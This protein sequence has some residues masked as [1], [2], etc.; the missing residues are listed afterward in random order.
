METACA[1]A[2][3]LF[4]CLIGYG[5]GKTRGI[6]EGREEALFVGKA[7]GFLEGWIARHNGQE[8]PDWVTDRDYPDWRYHDA[9]NT[10]YLNRWTDGDQYGDDA[11]KVEQQKLRNTLNGELAA[12][13]Q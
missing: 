10:A 3:V 13:G 1:I 5:V 6:R 9:K 2:G 12:K 7:D 8:V 4:F 11:Y